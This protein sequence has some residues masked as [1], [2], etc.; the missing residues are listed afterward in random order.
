[1]GCIISEIFSQMD[2]PIIDRQGCS[3]HDAERVANYFAEKVL[4]DWN[5]SLSHNEQSFHSLQQELFGILYTLRTRYSI[6]RTELTLV[7]IYVTKLVMSPELHDT[8]KLSADNIKLAILAAFILVRRIISSD[9][10][11]NI[12]SHIGFEFRENKDVLI[13]S[14]IYLFEKL[15]WKFSFSEDE[16]K[17]AEMI[18][19]SHPPSFSDPQL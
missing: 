4:K 12:F 2:I 1:M 18:L 8:F 16:K 13:D 10:C 11:K 19:T 7:L 14:E 17:N 3:V 6:S 9:G 15:G 5:G